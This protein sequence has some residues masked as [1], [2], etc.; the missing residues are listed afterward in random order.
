[1]SSTT[2]D[3]ENPIS[4]KYRSGTGTSYASPTIAGIIA[5]LKNMYPNHS[6]ND[7]LEIM[8]ENCERV[9]RY[10]EYGAGIPK[11]PSVKHENIVI[12]DRGVGRKEVQI[13]TTSAV[14]G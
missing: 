12:R 9:G 10:W 6:N 8:Y 11:F 3:K 14:T 7:L 1:I 2:I 5:L 13:K 4:K